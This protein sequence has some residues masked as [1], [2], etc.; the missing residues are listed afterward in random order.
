M[1]QTHALLVAAL[2]LISVLLAIAIVM[3]KSIKRLTHMQRIIEAPPSLQLREIDPSFIRP[4][5]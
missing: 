4:W 3:Y 2:V 1:D 5:A